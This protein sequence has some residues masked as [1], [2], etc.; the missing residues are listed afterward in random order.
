MVIREGRFGPYVTDGE[1]NASLRKGDSIEEITAARASEL[2]ADRRA[3]GPATGE[4]PPNH[5]QE[6]AGQE[7]DEER[8][9]RASRERDR[10]RGRGTSSPSRAAR[11]PARRPSSGSWLTRWPSAATRSSSRTSRATRRSGPSFA[12]LLLDPATVS[13]RADR[14]AALRRRP[15]RARGPCR[16][17]GARPRRRRHL[18]DRYIDSSIAYQGFGRGLDVEEVIRTSRWATGGLLPHLTLVLDLPAEEGLRRARGRSGRADRLEAEAI[19]FHERVRAG[20][21]QLAKAEPARYAV[22]A[23]TGAPDQVADAVRGGG[24]RPARHSAGGGVTASRPHRASRR[25]VGRA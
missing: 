17:A 9:A 11:A 18:T 21:L 1:T 13:H 3:R 20:F 10:E 8:P 22:I 14:S 16:D 5:G 23:A 2:L 6:G 24:L 7:G 15:G 25:G 4:G 19:D 12:Q